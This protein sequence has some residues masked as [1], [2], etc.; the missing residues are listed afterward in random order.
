MLI[1][2]SKRKKKGKN[3]R[4]AY[5]YMI[6]ST[7]LFSLHFVFIIVIPVINMMIIFQGKYSAKDVD[8]VGLLCNASKGK[9][10]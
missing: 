8:E 5:F 9:F 2:F 7:V 4:A 3:G 6:F 10:R 1:Y